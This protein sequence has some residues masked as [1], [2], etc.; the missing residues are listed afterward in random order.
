MRET[1]K[2]RRYR[3]TQGRC[4]ELAFKFVLDNPDWQLVHGSRLMASTD[5]WRYG[6]AWAEPRRQQFG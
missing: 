1:M 2:V 5:S 3:K 4:Y 6:H